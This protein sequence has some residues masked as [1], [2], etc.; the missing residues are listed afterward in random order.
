MKVAL[1]AETKEMRHLNRVIRHTF[2]SYRRKWNPTVLAHLILK[3][4]PDTQQEKIMILSLLPH[5]AVQVRFF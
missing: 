4:F 2:A 5:D 1:T 3:Y